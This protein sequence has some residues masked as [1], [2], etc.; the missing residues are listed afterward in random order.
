MCMS[1]LAHTCMY[2]WRPK[3]NTGVFFSPFLLY[4][5]KQ[6]PLES[7]ALTIQQVEQ[8]S[9][10]QGRISC[11]CPPATGMVADMPA[12]PPLTPPPVQTLA[13]TIQQASVEFTE[14]S[15]QLPVLYDT[16]HGLTESYYYVLGCNN[17]KRAFRNI[18]CQPD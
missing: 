4:L 1:T 14:L 10:P 16:K 2:T 11:L 13:L 6:G 7:P 18:L 9:L 8:A 15:L 3:V 12:R 17:K 5:L